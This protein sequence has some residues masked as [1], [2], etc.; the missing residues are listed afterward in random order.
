MNGT[1]LNSNVTTDVY[2]YYYSVDQIL[3]WYGSYLILDELNLYLV[4]SVSLI[5]F[6]LNVVSYFIL[7]NRSVF[8][9]SLDLFKYLRVYSVNNAVFCLLTALGFVQFTYRIFPW[10]NSYWPF[11]YIDYIFVPVQTILYTYCSFLNIAILIDRIAIYDRNVSNW[12]KL[13]AGWVN[14]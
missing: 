14:S 8:R 4:T 9:P 11:V 1:Y 13:S 2:Y 12:L 6:A 10:T 7:S 5:G 3:N